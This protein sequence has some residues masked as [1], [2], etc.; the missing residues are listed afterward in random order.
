M[1]VKDVMDEAVEVVP[2]DAPLGVAVQT[3]LKHDGGLVAVAKEG[4]LQG[5]LSEHDIIQWEAEPGH[6][7]MTALV[8]DVM[9]PDRLF[10]DEK[11]DIR[12][13]VR[14]MKQEHVGALLVAR[15]QQAIGKVALSDLAT[16]MSEDG[17]STQSTQSSPTTGT[18]AGEFPVPAFG[19]G[20]SVAGTV[21]LRPVASPSILGFF[22]LAAAA[23]VV[24]A[25]SA[26]WY[27]TAAT[28][29]YILAFVALFGGVAQFTAGMWAYVARDGLGTAVHGTWGAFW[30][31][32]GVMYLMV[33]NGVLTLGS[34]NMNF[35]FLFIPLCAI[36]AVCTIAAV[37]D[38][39]AEALTLLVLSIAT[40]IAAVA[41]LVGSSNWISAAGYVL[42]LGAIFAWY[43][44]SAALL[45]GS[46]RRMMLPTSRPRMLARKLGDNFVEAGLKPAS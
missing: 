1:L 37:A 20:S 21:F 16:K 7:P 23:L 32:Y 33:A 30:A 24:G 18:M 29:M 11:Q 22:G 46:W 38:R 42:M 3:L 8:G 10:L 12:E 26:G 36:T 43:V 4:K 6:D 17:S 31:A 25:H 9:R 15:D 5:T 35:G 13:A 19:A 44:G 14:I 28:P 2:A 34:V 41:M 27:G 40:G 45:E 39:W